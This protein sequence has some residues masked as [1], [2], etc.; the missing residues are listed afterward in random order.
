MGVQLVTD[1]EC[2]WVQRNLEVNENRRAYEDFPHGVPRTPKI[3]K[4]LE[5]SVL[6]P[7]RLICKPGTVLPHRHRGDS[8]IWNRLN[9]VSG[10]IFHI[11]KTLSPQRRNPR[12]R[13]VIAKGRNANH[14]TLILEVQGARSGEEPGSNRRRGINPI[15]SCGRP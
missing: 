12:A 6:Y 8:A 7:M 11:P 14:E 10:D 4:R 15:R 9:G 13:G 1:S 3:E 2:D 5:T